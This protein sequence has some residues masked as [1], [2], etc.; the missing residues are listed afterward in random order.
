[1]GSMVSTIIFQPLLLGTSITL[2][3]IALMYQNKACPTNSVRRKVGDS[4]TNYGSEIFKLNIGLS[5][6]IIFIAI[7]VG[8]MS[9]LMV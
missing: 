6:V 7:I 1:M 2:M 5:I 4:P 3:V 9:A 8:F